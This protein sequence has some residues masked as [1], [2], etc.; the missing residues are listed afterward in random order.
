MPRHTLSRRTILLG[1]SAILAL[2]VVNPANASYAHAGNQE[3][4][5]QGGAVDT[6]DG[7]IQWL[8]Q[9]MDELG[10]PGAAVGVVS[11]DRRFTHGIGVANA[12]TGATFTPSTPFGI[13]SL[14]KIFTATAL[15]AF[16]HD[17]ALNLNDKVRL[18]LPD[19]ALADP[20]ASDAV[21]VGH[22]LSHGGGW[23]DVLEPV[24]GQDSLA[25]YAAHMTDVPQIAPVGTHFSYSNSGFLLAGAVGKEVTGVPYE[26]TIA[27]SILRPLGMTN[28][29]F[30]NDPETA[31]NRAVGH[32]IIDGQ[33]TVI[34]NANPPRPINPAAGLITTVDDMLSFLEAHTGIGDTQLDPDALSSM[35]Q[36]RNT[37]GSLGPVV[38]DQIGTGWMLL[39]IEGEHVLMSQ[40]G[41]S[42]L[43][44]AMVAVPARKFG[45]IFMANSESAMMLANDAVLKGLSDFLGLAIPD[46]EP[47]TLSRDEA[48]NGEG[49]FEVPGWLT[50]ATSAADGSL[51]LETS[52]EGNVIPDF[53]GPLTMT[54]P[55]LGFLPY[56]GSRIWRDLV[57]DET[58]A[59]AWVR[60]AARLAPRIA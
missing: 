40:G 13:A 6:F 17:G 55:T 8:T 59:I 22:L 49:R 50:L 2:P 5:P 31:P 23:A 9:K 19:F 7:L 3:P 28:S 35:R 18:H 30:A 58:G 25:W 41:D 24:A 26:A 14:T 43:M 36:P 16:A 46:P 20:A 54:S 27:N 45:M 56:L 29:G 44:S 48:A 21:T 11:G 4:G 38:V 60:F 33:L 1:A 42:G 10:V 53:T 57:P 34:A 51:Q 32:Q 37:G 12:D 52:A 15:A 39:E 47:S